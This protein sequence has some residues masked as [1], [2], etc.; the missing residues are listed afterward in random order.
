MELMI[1]NRLV[2]FFLESKGV[3]DDFQ[4][5]FRSRRSTMELVAVLD[6]DI[7]KQFVNK[8]IILS[9]FLDIEKA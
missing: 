6:Q 8:E 1:T 4:N 3:F 5:G 9:V 7:K 2:F